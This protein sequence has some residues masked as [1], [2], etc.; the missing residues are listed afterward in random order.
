MSPIANTSGCPGTLRSVST[1]MRPPLVSSTPSISASGLARTPAAHTTTPAGSTVPSAEVD[2]AKRTVG[3]DAVNPDADTTSTP[4]RDS[5]RRARSLDFG[6][7]AP[8]NRG[9]ASTRTTRAG[10]HVEAREVLGEHPGEQL[11]HR[12]GRLDA[13]RPTAAEHDVELAPL[14]AG[15]SLAARSKRSS[16]ARRRS[17]ASSRSLS[18]IVCS[19]TP[20]MPND[21][22]TAPAATTSVSYRQ[23][24]AGAVAMVERDDPGV[25][26]DVRDRRHVHVDVALAAEHATDGVGDVVGVEPGRGDLVEQRLEQVE[27]VGVDDVDVNGC[28]GQA[29]GHRQPAEPGADHHDP[30]AL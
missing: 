14:D 25:E 15:G 30:L 1:T 4:R 11:H 28:P 10:P 20:S 22:D 7:I 24:V 29:L 23:F 2:V 18:G 8:S 12:P 13:G 16:T 17:R 6:D 5:V 26:V 21:V 9:A 3:V 27:V 19:S